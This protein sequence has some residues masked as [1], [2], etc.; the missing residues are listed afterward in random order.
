LIF[1]VSQNTPQIP[2]LLIFP[3]IPEN[4]SPI[5]II[6]SEDLSEIGFCIDPETSAKTAVSHFILR[7]SIETSAADSIDFINCFVYTELLSISF[8]AL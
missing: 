3:T 4:K 8:R 1:A 5:S 6:C 2:L 7:F